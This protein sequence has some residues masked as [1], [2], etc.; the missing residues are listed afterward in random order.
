MRRKQCNS[1]KKEDNS[2]IFTFIVI[3]EFEVFEVFAEFEVH[4]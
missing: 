3:E 1:R 2:Y 4:E